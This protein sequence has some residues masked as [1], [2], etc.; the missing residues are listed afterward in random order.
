M[1]ISQRMNSGN[2]EIGKLRGQLE[3]VKNTFW[4]YLK[5]N[6]WVYDE[7]AL[8]L[9]GHIAII[10]NTLYHAEHEDNRRRNWR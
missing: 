8:K 3:K 2:T 4:E 5:Q 10:E 7:K 6:G 1:A 9:E